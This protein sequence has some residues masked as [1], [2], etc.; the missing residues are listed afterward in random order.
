VLVSK[1]GTKRVVYTQTDTIWTTVH[2][3]EK[4]DLDEIEDEIIAK[5]YAALD[6]RDDADVKQLV[7]V[8]E[9]EVR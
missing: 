7:Q 3:T 8:L 5:D 4:V 2:L 6:V 9:S 1:A